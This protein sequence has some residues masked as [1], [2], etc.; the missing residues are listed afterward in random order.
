MKQNFIVIDDSELDCFIAEKMINHAVKD[1]QV[2][3]FTEARKALSHIETAMPDSGRTIILLDILM[4]VMDGFAFME[5]YEKLPEK[6]RESYLVMGLTS[7]MNKRDLNRLTE[8]P[9][10][11]R[12]IDKPLTAE[13]VASLLAETGKSVEFND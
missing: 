13:T 4:P 11:K 7:S 10:L 8:Y 9:S 3:L 6:I 12:L 2:L 1:S 5:S